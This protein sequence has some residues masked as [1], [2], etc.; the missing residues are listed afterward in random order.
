MDLSQLCSA[1]A[2]AKRIGIHVRQ[3]RNLQRDGHIVPHRV[4]GAADGYPLY[5]LADCD[6]LK[7]ER[8]RVGYKKQATGGQQ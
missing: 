4:D 5:A 3:L 7:R 6:R 2:A 8:P 1:Q